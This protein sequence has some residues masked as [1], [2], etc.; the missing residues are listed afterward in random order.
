MVADGR[1][2]GHREARAEEEAAGRVLDHL[3]H[4]GLAEE[5]PADA[6]EHLREGGHQ[7]RDAPLDPLRLGEAAT[8]LAERAAPVRV[9]DGEHRVV[10]AR[11]CRRTPAGARRLRR[12]SRPPRRATSAFFRSRVFKMRSRLLAELW[13]KKRTSGCAPGSPGGEEGPVED[14][15]VAVAV[16]DERRVLVG[17]RGD[18]AEHRLV[19]GREDEALLVAEPAARGAPRARRA[20]PSWPGRASSTGRTRTCRSPSWPPPSPSDG[21]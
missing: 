11:R 8:V 17:E 9:V 4:L 5:R 14:A 7:D 6:A 18:E 15:G 16:E 1:D 13:L 3:D 10:A 2:D 20:R 19:A 21:S 12:A